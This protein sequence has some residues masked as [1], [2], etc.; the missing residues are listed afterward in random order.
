MRVVLLIGSP[1]PKSSTSQIL[2]TIITDRLASNHG[3]EIA[4]HHAH[5]ALRATRFM[6]A[7]RADI[8]TADLLLMSF[9]VYVD[10]LP[11]VLT[12]VLE[13]LYS[14]PPTHRAAVAAVANCGFP[15]ADHTHVS[16]G[17]CAQFAYAMDMPWH[18]GIGIGEGTAVNGAPLENLGPFGAR[19][20]QTLHE[21]ADALAARAPIPPEVID[22]AARPMMPKRMYTFLGTLGWNKMARDNDARSVMWA[23]P[24]DS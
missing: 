17:I 21:A 22:Q 6:E 10:S 3:A 14:Q 12:A 18:G 4:I 24:Y 19:L 13:A 23:R 2:G 1:K 20:K 16:L 7:L 5:R 15:E 9:P 11:Y 8:E